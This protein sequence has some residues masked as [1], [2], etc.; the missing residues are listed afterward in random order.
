[1][2]FQINRMV[3][4]TYYHTVYLKADRSIENNTQRS[5]RWRP[6][7][8]WQPTEQTRFTFS[9][10]VRATYTVDDFELAGR[11]K[12]DQSARELRFDTTIEHRWPDESRLSL[13]SDF[14]DLRLGRLLWAAFA[15]IPFDT[16]Q[17]YSGWA[18]YRVGTTW[19]AEVGLR[20]FLRQD[21]NRNLTLYYNQ[22]DGNGEPVLGI[23]GKP[24]RKALSG[25]GWEIIRQ[26]GPTTALALPLGKGSSLRA[27]GWLQYQNIRQQLHQTLP[28]LPEVLHA[29]RKGRTQLFPNISIGVLWRW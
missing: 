24:V 14:S 22:W 16:V 13:T 3:L 20:L 1:I 28:D 6:A 21:Y 25:A 11:L 7:I 26:L 19:T 23:D 8:R 10:E 15:E 9:P 18:R 2:G 5:L 29:A 27:E 4:G 12:N 17:T